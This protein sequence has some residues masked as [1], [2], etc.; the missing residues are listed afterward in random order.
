MLDLTGYGLA[1]NPFNI[2]PADADHWSG[3]DRERRLLWD[4]VRSASYDDNGLSEF[5]ILIGDWGSGKTHA[6]KYLARRVNKGQPDTDV[7][8]EGDAVAIPVPKVKLGPKVRWL[9]IYQLIVKQHL[10]RDFFKRL[11]SRFLVLVN[12]C[13]EELSA[14][15]DP[16]AYRKIIKNDT[17]HFINK[18]VGNLEDEDQPYAKLLLSVS[19][20]VE[21]AVTY[22]TE[23]SRLPSHINLPKDV[24]NDYDA[25]QVLA[26]IFRVMTLPVM[27]KAPVYKAVHLSIDEVEELLEVKATEQAEFWFGTRELI[28]R[29]PAR[30][31]FI[32]AFSAEAPMLEATMAPAVQ[33]RKTRKNV[34][35]EAFSPGDASAFVERQ[36]A[37]FRPSAWAARQSFH[38]FTAEAVD[39]VLEQTVPLVPRRIFIAL[40]QVLD[41]A[42]RHYDLAPGEEVDRGLAEKIVVEFGI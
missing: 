40:R 14:N 4:V 3:R 15:I 28:N 37:H 21:D 22:L 32:L 19:D 41:K 6:L 26:G 23:G 20:D 10:G 35:F 2:V 8:S 9:D 7:A 34:V 11:A 1:A 17:N 38:P 36:L 27:N 25:V 12:E 42:I 39:Y 31:A 29:V 16:S 24:K 30:M 33:E 18:V 13:A 5:V